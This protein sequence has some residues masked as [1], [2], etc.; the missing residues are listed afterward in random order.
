MS[1]LAHK[2]VIEVR[3]TREF[4]SLG[5]DNINFVFQYHPF[6]A[7]HPFLASWQHWP[8]LERGVRGRRLV[9]C[10]VRCILVDSSQLLQDDC[11]W[12]TLDSLMIIH[13]NTLNILMN[14]SHAMTTNIETY[15]QHW[16]VCFGTLRT[17]YF[18]QFDH[19]LIKCHPQFV[20]SIFHT[21]QSSQSKLYHNKYLMIKL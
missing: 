6:W 15:F 20:L 3:I 9:T 17:V 4:V 21:T 13:W 1:V 12:Q 14:S 10:R 18:I 8:V 19:L 2:H 5:L 11:H 7:Y 16:L